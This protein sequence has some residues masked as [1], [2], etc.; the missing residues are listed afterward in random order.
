MSHLLR[1]MDMILNK[2]YLFSIIV[3]N[4]NIVLGI[5]SEV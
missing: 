5:T 1:E 4:I 3:L 2:V